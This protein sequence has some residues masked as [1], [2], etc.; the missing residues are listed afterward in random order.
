[1]WHLF[2]NSGRFFQIGSHFDIQCTRL[3]LK[4][5]DTILWNPIWHQ[6]L[7]SPISQ[8]FQILSVTFAQ[9]ASYFTF[10]ACVSIP[11]KLAS[12]SG[13]HDDI[14]SNYLSSGILASFSRNAILPKSIHD[15]YSTREQFLR[16]S[17]SSVK[18]K[19]TLDLSGSHLAC[20]V[21]VDVSRVIS[22]QN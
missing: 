9:I 14:W 8:S 12:I 10:S 20:S 6:S 5:I 1:M 18:F 3:N 2:W 4:E 7:S 13:N 17:N 16:T 15:Y 19:M 22:R 11:E 21:C